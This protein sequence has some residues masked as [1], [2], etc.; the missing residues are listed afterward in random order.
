MDNEIY[1]KTGINQFE[2][3]LRIGLSHH[4]NKFVRYIKQRFSNNVE[5]QQIKTRKEWMEEFK[6][7]FDAQ[8]E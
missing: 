6:V 1:R 4:V 8:R 2:A 3:E 7:W 5:L